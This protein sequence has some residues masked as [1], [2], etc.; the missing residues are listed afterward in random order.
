MAH[1]TAKFIGVRNYYYNYTILLIYVAL[2]EC[3]KVY[4]II[5]ATNAD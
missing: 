4:I 3:S 1:L 2:A 5:S